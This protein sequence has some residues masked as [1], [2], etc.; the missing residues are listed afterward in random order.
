LG[1]K[2]A[3][4]SYQRAVLGLDWQPLMPINVSRNGN[5]VTVQFHVPVPPLN[6]DSSFDAPAIAEWKNG[7]GFELFT[8][9]GN[10]TISSVAISGDSVQIT[11]SGTLPATDLSVGYAITSQGKQL[12]N[13]SK[14]VRWGQL[15]DSDPFTG[16]ITKQTNPNYA[17]SFYLPVP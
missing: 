4:I 17:V 9:T 12:S 14:S 13:H 3:Q 16:A 15:R 6:W 2:T 1:E 10:I 8:S 11:A 5:V 7:K